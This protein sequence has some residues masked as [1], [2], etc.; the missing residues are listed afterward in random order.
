MPFF[1]MMYDHYNAIV[2]QRLWLQS[3]VSVNKMCPNLRK[4]QPKLVAQYTPAIG[5]QISCSIAEISLHKINNGFRQLLQ[6]NKINC[7]TE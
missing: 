4:E 1:S 2:S 7:R 5:F 3:T 6:T